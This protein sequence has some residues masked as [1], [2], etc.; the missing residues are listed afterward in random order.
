M[1]KVYITKKTYC[2][3]YITNIN[4]CFIDNKSYY[5][6]I[7]EVTDEELAYLKLKYADMFS[8]CYIDEYIY[9]IR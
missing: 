4:F 3:E 8:I 6:Y 1:N 7:V 9:Y 2:N 5:K